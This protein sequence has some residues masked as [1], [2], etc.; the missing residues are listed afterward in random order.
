M[1]NLAPA[2]EP[3]FLEEDKMI[4]GS[5]IILDYGITHKE[6]VSHHTSASIITRIL[7]YKFPQLFNGSHKSISIKIENEGVEISND[8]QKLHPEL[9][10]T[11]V[12]FDKKL[13]S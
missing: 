9:A 3:H 6:F 4:K 11:T 5:V 1:S 8:Y 13:G 12:L 2:I 10:L 7:R